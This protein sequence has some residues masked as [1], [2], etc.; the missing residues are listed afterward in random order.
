[1]TSKI[2]YKS[3]V[4]RDLRKISSKEVDRILRQVRATLG[5]N[6]QSGER[7]HGDFEGLLKLRIGE[8]RV[9]YAL[10]DSDVIVLR[11]RHRSKAYD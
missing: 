4:S 11:I 1:M 3:S 9:V 2:L 6:P 10:S 8:Y 5:D 7:L